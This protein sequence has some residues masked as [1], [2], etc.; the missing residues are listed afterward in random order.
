MPPVSDLWQHST[1]PSASSRSAL[2]QTEP[3]P[4]LSESGRVRVEGAVDSGCG[5][6]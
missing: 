5:A 3:G 6:G 1:A 2:S 4:A